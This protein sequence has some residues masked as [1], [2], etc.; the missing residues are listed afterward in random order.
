MDTQ[1]TL[2]EPVLAVSMCSARDCLNRKAIQATSIL[3]LFQPLHTILNSYQRKS[4]DNSTGTL[5]FGPLTASSQPTMALNNASTT[6]AV[7]SGMYMTTQPS[8]SG[9][10]L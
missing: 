3:L 8:L 9:C 6:W 5:D 4:H 7:G 1:G 10:L 2:K